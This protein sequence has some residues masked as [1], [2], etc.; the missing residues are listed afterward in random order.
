MET[1][2]NYLPFLLLLIC[3]ISMMFMHKGHG[4]HNHDKEEDHTKH[5][6]ANHELILLRKQTEQLKEEV[7]ILKNLVKERI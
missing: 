5:T 3:P 6:E 4:G 1:I 7:S 2:L